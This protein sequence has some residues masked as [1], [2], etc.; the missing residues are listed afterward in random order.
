MYSMIQPA[1]LAA[2]IKGAMPLAELRAPHI[3]VGT[4]LRRAG[5]RVVKLDVG[6]EWMSGCVSHAYTR[7]HEC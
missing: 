6:R 4:F 3:A 2:N 1:P 5:A 7:V